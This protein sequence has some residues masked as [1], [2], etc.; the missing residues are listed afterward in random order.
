MIFRLI[1]CTLISFPAF[2]DNQ[3]VM[4]DKADRWFQ[5]FQ[6]ATPEKQ[7][8]MLERRN[9]CLKLPEEQR[10]KECGKGHNK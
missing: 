6:N 2:G 10:K 4:I 1:L 7:A 8:K 9:Y 3:Q 5:K